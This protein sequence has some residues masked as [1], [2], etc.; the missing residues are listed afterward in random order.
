MALKTNWRR[1][2]IRMLIIAFGS[3]LIPCVLLAIFQ[4]DLL[5]HPP[6]VNPAVYER[7]GERLGMVRW[8]NA[9]GQNI[10]WKKLSST[11]PPLGQVMITYGNGRSALGC[12]HYVDA[13][14]RTGMDVYVLEYPDYA[15]RLGSPSQA[16]FFKA[17]E[18]GFSMLP[19]NRPTYLLG[20]SLGTGVAAYL[21]G[22]HPD[23]ITGMVLLAPYNK[24]VDVAQAHFPWFPV[25]LLLIDRFNSASYLR[26]YRGPVSILTGMADRV[27]PERF[28]LR[29]F[30]GYGGLKKLWEF[31]G[32]DHEDVFDHFDEKWPEI[33]AFWDLSLPVPTVG[34]T[35]AQK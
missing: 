10:G 32:A 3:Y 33:K 6:V 12:Y 2:T 17:A 1:K 22:T 5:Y 34:P 18:E 8:Q 26:N 16:S 20:E 7:T 21:A 31:P 4:R 29:L 19:T 24:L 28:G 14:Q 25:R 13:M 35:A 27:V 30:T 11:Q 9:S 23:R 15:D